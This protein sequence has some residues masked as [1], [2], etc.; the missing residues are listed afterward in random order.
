M[1][2]VK[3]LVLFLVAMMSN[4]DTMSSGKKMRLND[5]RTWSRI[6]RTRT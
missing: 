3:L 4:S 5:G 2:S 6:A 1:W